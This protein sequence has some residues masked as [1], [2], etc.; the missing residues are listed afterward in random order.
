MKPL[1][2]CL[3]AGCLVSPVC[4]Q[5]RNWTL[6]EFLQKLEDGQPWTKEKAEAQLGVK[7]TKSSSTGVVTWWYPDPGSFVYGEGLIVNNISYDVWTKTNEMR[8]MRANEMT[9]MRIGLDDKS[10]CFTQ[11]RI[12]K[13][14]PGGKFTGL[15]EYPGGSDDYYINRGWG[16]VT[17][18]FGEKKQWKC[19]TG[20]TITIKRVI[21]TP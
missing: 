4:A 9:S 6:E 15:N 16:G 5:E 11:E 14:Y 3:L 17:F 13:S 18:A 1:L 2:T 12:K 21:Y 7:L 8:G 19:L 20:I 10:S